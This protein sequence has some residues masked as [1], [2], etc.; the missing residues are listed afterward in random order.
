MQ[1]AN[2]LPSVVSL[3]GV[4]TVRATS[5]GN[6]NANYFMLIPVKTVIVSAAASGANAVISFPSTLGISYRVMSNSSLTSGTWSVAATV[7]GNGG[8]KT[9]SIPAT[10]G[11]QFFK[12]VSP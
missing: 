10:A 5:A 7:T 12:V 4:N 9:V 8:T 2:G 6:V 11:T 1:S 3:N